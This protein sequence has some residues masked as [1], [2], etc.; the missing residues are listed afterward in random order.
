M[1]YQLPGPLLS[2]VVAVPGT[3]GFSPPVDNIEPLSNEILLFGSRHNK[4]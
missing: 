2:I 4:D 1:L 3:T